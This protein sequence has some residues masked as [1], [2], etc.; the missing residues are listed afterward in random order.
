MSWY[1]EEA[2]AILSSNGFEEWEVEDDSV[3]VC[4]H[5]DKIEFDGYCP[6]GCTSPF[7]ELGII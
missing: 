3:I 5:G 1:A 6:R 4:P 7:L 2:Q